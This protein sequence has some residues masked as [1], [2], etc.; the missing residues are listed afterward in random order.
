MRKAW[1]WCAAAGIVAFTVSSLFARIPGLVACGPTGGLEPIIAFELARTTADV[2]TLFG[3]EPCT[4]TLVAAQKTGLLLD[5]LG[6]IP[7]Y[8]AFLILGAIAA[9]ARGRVRQLALALFLSAALSDEIEGFLLGAI[10]DR[11]PGTPALL[12]GLWWAV[13]VKFGLLALG[14]I[15]IGAILCNTSW[16]RR[17]AAGIMI[18]GGLF[19]FFGLV[20]PSAGTMMQGFLIAWVAL[21]LTALVASFW[22]RVFSTDS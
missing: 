4:S 14:T 11:L 20:A 7:S 12:H 16:R 10:L 3:A 1:R 21:L 19:A 8:T 13:H 22:P 9:G 15:Q 6:F 17:I 18:V 2:A 5:G